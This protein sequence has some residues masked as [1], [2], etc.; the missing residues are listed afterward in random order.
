VIG[1]HDILPCHQRE[2]CLQRVAHVP[3]HILSCV[4]PFKG[5]WSQTPRKYSMLSLI[6]L[7]PAVSGGPHATDTRM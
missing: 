3:M 2:D 6:C 5:S 7:T 4:F 1:H